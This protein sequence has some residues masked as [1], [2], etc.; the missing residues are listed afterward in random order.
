M[1]QFKKGQIPWNKAEWIEKSCPTMQNY[2]L[3]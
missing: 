3:L 1:G 2:L